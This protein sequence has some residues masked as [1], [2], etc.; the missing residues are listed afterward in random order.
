MR[1]TRPAMTPDAHERAALSK[2]CLRG[3]RR[4]RAIPD[5]EATIQA[6][7]HLHRAA[8]IRDSSDPETPD[9]QCRRLGITGD[10]RKR[11][12]PRDGNGRYRLTAK[13]TRRTYRRRSNPSTSVSEKEMN[14]RRAAVLGI[15]VGSPAWDDLMARD[16]AF[17]TRLNRMRAAAKPNTDDQ[18]R[19]TRGKS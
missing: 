8:V 16:R 1:T 7:G 9:A 15:T 5:D 19:S 18:G 17:L 2:L 10:L 4:S 13:Q 11:L 12:I 14:E 6:C 3:A